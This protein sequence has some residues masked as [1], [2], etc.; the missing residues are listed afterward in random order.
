[1]VFR[2]YNRA[3][4]DEEDVQNP[5]ALTEEQAGQMLAEMNEVI[6]AGEEMRLLRAE[7]IKVLV[8]LGWTQEKIARLTDMSQPAVSK[9]V[10]KYRS[11]DPLPR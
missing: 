11:A 3:M 7:M 1:M 6:R 5:T 9:Q 4:A 8:G 10:A 2:V